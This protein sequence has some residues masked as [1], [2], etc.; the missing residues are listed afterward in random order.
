[1]CGILCVLGLQGP[2]AVKDTRP[3]VRVL[4]KRLRHRGPDWSGTHSQS[5][6]AILGHE[7]LGIM[8]PESG[9]QPLL[10]TTGEIAIAV[11][12]EIYN[13]L[14]L[15][16]RYPKYVVNFGAYNT[17]KLK[18]HKSGTHSRPEVIV[19]SFFRCT[20]IMERRNLLSS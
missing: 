12:G 20:R 14:E 6:G 9:D 16:K 2:Q 1:M 7:R 5:C 11:N 15:R 4:Q 3:K 17:K 18:Q 8:D 13:H 19:R 10:D